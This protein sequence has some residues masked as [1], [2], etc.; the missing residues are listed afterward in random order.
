[1]P[2]TPMPSVRAGARPAQVRFFED[3]DLAALESAVNAWLAENSRCEIV[4][5]QQSVITTPAQ[6]RQVVVSIWYAE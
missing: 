2:S 6:P 4:A 3:T 1:M 5:I